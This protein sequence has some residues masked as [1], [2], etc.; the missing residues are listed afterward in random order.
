MNGLRT[1]RK[2]GNRCACW[3]LALIVGAIVA[4]CS[5]IEDAPAR[6]E[7]SQRPPDQEVWGWKT[8]L[9]EGGRRR[10]VVSAGHY[11]RYDRSDKADLSGGVTI[12]FLDSSGETRSKLTARQAEIAEKTRDM[13]VFGEVVLV[14]QDS[15]R[16]ETDSLRWHHQSEKIAG[17]GN[18][19]IRR[20]DGVETGVGFEATSD[21]KR[22]TLRQVITRLGRADSLRN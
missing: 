8:T 6:T 15:T 19:T 14:A 18:V 17:E 5:K 20:P 9:T 1:G 12:Q 21:L 11:Q 4:G 2:G 22:W 13:V 3:A 16:L 10:A 7:P